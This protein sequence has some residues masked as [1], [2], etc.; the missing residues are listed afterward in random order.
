[1]EGIAGE[2]REMAYSVY[3]FEQMEQKRR[4][5]AGV[6]RA[7]AGGDHTDQGGKHLYGQY[8][9]K[10]APGWNRRF[11]KNG[12]QSIGRSRGGLTTKIHMVTASDRAVVGFSLSGGQAHDA[13]EGIVLLE[14]MQ[15]AQEQ[16]YLLMDRAYEGENVREAAVKMGFTPVVPPKKNRKDTWDYD[17]ERYKRRNEIERYFL[18]LKRFR[19]IFTRYDKLDVMFSGFIYFAMVVDAVL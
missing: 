6:R 8:H 16:K 15:R 4:A 19:R 3:S 10:S 1:M 5:T 14:E 13:P 2:I 11:K 12:P 7:A 18:R 17:K 9:G